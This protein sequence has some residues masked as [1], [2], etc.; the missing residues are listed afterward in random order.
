MKKENFNFIV[1]NT[2]NYIKENNI[3]P[4]DMNIMRSLSRNKNSVFSNICLN[5]FGEINYNK[6]L[7]LRQMWMRNQQGFFFILSY[8]SNNY[9]N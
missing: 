1:E 9:K 6:V 5:L 7:E 2:L 3:D 8:C 4:N